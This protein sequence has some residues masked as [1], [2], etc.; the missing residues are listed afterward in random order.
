MFKL[1]AV[2]IRLIDP[3]GQTDRATEKGILDSVRT[4]GRR[5]MILESKSF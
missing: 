5:Q 2:E 1:K 4:F 3:G